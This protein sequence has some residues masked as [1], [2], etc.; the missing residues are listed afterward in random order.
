MWARMALCIF[1]TGYSGL[2]RRAIWGGVGGRSG[3]IAA[4]AAPA[5]HATRAKVDRII[6]IM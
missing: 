6:G 4:R 5:A 2:R 3:E 1:R